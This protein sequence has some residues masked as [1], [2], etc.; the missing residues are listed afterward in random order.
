MRGEGRIYKQKGSSFFW[1]A[2]YLRGKQYRESTGTTDEDKAAKY[3]KRRLKEVGADQ[4]GLKQFIGP[5]AERIKISCG[6]ISPE[7]RKADC[8][9]LC[10]ALERDF[11]LRDK[12]SPQ[13]L[14]N[15]SRLTTISSSNWRKATL[16]RQSIA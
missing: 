6:I 15:F 1:C 7:Q 5:Q 13:N 10:C 3:L 9:C 8:D 2:Y 14:S 4:I 11:R 12:A 16:P